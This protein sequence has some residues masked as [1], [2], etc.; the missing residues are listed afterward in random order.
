[1]KICFVKESSYPDLW[2]GFGLEGKEILITN[3]HM[4]ICPAGLFDIFN[5][6]YYLLKTNSSRETLE[7][8]G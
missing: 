8:Q 2:I 1:M 4:S 3:M 5:A 7:N 6:D